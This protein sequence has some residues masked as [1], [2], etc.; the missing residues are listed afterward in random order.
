[1]SFC[2]DMRFPWKPRPVIITCNSPTKK[3]FNCCL[4][5]TS[6]VT[7]S[8][9]VSR[10][11][12]DSERHK[13]SKLMWEFYLLTVVS[14]F[15]REWASA[16]LATVRTTARAFKENMMTEREGSEDLKVLSLVVIWCHVMSC[17]VM[18]CHVMSCWVW[19]VLGWQNFS[20]WWPE[21]NWVWL[22]R[23]GPSTTSIVV[24]DGGKSWLT[25]W[26]EVRWGEQ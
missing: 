11:Y 2:I 1:M 6:W 8:S 21:L 14:L 26:G 9:L 16:R 20:V 23:P 10:L 15:C 5:G 13:Y 7:L 12:R 4:W 18:W 19:P 25:R 24:G 3:S 17:D 22:S